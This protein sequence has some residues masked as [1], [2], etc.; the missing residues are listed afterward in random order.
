[1][2]FEI[3]RNDIV[4]MQ[5]DA[6]VNTANPKPVI[7]AGVDSRIHQKAG[8]QLIE[9]RRKIGD[10]EIGQA[11][12]T[13]GFS[14]PAKYVIHTAGPLWRGGDFEE[15]ALLGKSYASAL[16]IAAE[17][18]CESV[19]FP[20]LSAGSYG[21]PREKALEIALASFHKFL[22]T[23]D[24]DIYLVVFGKEVLALSEKLVKSVASYIDDRYTARIEAEEYAPAYR[25]V[26]GLP[27]EYAEIPKP[28]AKQDE[29]VTLTAWDTPK[30][31]AAA[32][33][34]PKTSL[35]E[36]VKRTEETFSQSL[37]RLIDQK[38]FT[39]PQVY[40]RANVDRK[41]FN[42]IKNTPDYQPKKVTAV[43]FAIA[44]GLN[45]D[46]AKDLIGRAGFALTHASKFDIIVEYFIQRENYNLME[47]N[48]VLFEFGQ[49]TIGV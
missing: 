8:A 7:G 33:A 3:V 19:A 6:V 26:R 35:E 34:A 47:I 22:L 21:F 44:L 36:L 15:E 20:L 37:I 28:A 48:A 16:A 38:G 25:A 24:M 1:M 12:I 18:G 40:K 11:V 30:A 42:K 46:E 23:H 2:P 27:E 17:Y 14:L 5:V 41:L 49:P 9:A 31:C 39:D 4:N 29:A 13:S 45:L 43:A 32:P 10:I